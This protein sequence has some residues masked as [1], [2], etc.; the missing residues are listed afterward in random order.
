MTT[1]TIEMKGVQK[2]F[3]SWAG[4]ERGERM[5]IGHDALVGYILDSWDFMNVSNLL[6]V[7]CGNGRAL[8]QAYK[9][10]AENLAGLDLSKN[11]IAEAKKNIPEADLRRGSAANMKFWKD[12]TFSHLMSV[13]AM[14]Y[15]DDP[16]EGVKEM[17]R[18]LNGDGKVAV[19]IDYYEENTGTHSWADA[20]GIKLVRLSEQDWASMF[21]D[22]GF[23]D[24]GLTR[25]IRNEHVM[26]KP[27]FQPSDYFPDYDTY[28]EY[29]AEGA[30]LITNY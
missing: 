14:Y 5:A 18:V 22:A 7:G 26:T 28:K 3:D 20:L 21:M 25:I 10:G 16:M 2:V 12:D 30:L 17:K 24:V 13:E 19:A 23:S 6:D 1:N 11:M 29:I 9:R 8:V 15:L 4:T 27:E